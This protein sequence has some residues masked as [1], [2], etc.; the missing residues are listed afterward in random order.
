MTQ[1]EPQEMPEFRTFGEASGSS[2]AVGRDVPGDALTDLDAPSGDDAY[3]YN[4]RTGEVTRG[5]VH[6]WSYRMGPYRTR[7]EAANALEIAQARAAAWDE[8]DRRWSNG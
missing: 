3:Y 7:E 4:T 1:R 8:E 2:D 6:S 5:R